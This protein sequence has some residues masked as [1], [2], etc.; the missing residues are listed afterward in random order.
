M[1]Y[2][3]RFF[4]FLLLKCS[5]VLF[6]TIEARAQLP[7]LTDTTQ[8]GE[9]VP[10]WPEDSLGRRNPRGTVEGFIKAVADEDYSR[11]AQYLRYDP[12]LK[13]NQDPEKLARSLQ[14]LLDKNGTIFPY[15]LISEEP[16]GHDDDNMGPNLDRIGVASVNNEQFDLILESTE[17]EDGGPIWLFSSETIERVP[18][19]TEEA[20]IAPLIDRLSP[21]VLN[22]TKWSGVPVAHWL[23]SLL[24]IVGS[25]LLTW[26]AT[27]ILLFLIPKVWVRARTEP[28]A[29]VILAFSLPIRLYVTIWVFTIAARQA[30]IS[31]ILRQRF[32]DLLVIVA[33]IALLLLIWQLLEFSTRYAERLLG[34]RGNQ[35]GV[36][37]VL[38]LR[39]AA[40]VALV[41]LAV[42]LILST[43]GFD[44]TTGLA[45]LGIGGIALALGAQKTVENFVG[46][47]T[48]I[49]DQPVRVG[50][51]CR[52]G[53][54][55][56]TVEQIGMRSTRI[57]TNDRTVVTI[58]NGDFSSQKIENFAHRERFWFHP[59][60]H[61]RLETTPDQIR[62][63]LVEMRKILYGHPKIDPTSARVRLVGISR[64]AMQLEIYSY[65]QTRDYDR[66]LEIQ[67]DIYLR[68]LDVVASSGTRLALPSQTL[69]LG[70]D[71]GLSEEKTLQAEEQVR[72]WRDAGELHVPGFT[73]EAIQNIRN[74]IE[75]PPPGSSVRPPS[76]EDQI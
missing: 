73:E 19:L 32:G 56:G 2:N 34:F 57:R 42:I 71:R 22:D 53:D 50:D 11:A 4:L 49:A 51:Y 9:A 60:F 15:S 20:P 40:K 58:P 27:R 6:L 18:L 64:D 16:A 48:L 39:R 14:Q 62:F 21:D 30:G 47:V 38:F 74:T 46:S 44:V 13:Q 5:F 54:T 3:S 70:R 31:I 33:L 25:Y 23:A 67:E 55:S 12:K 43:L 41:F 17:G 7:G 76:E 75:Y 29:G 28:T 26:L 36:S 61:L 72:S 65:I 68:L 37:A 59:I 24:L 69:Y 1:G 63:L 10:A 52:V 66:Y 45:A 8:K 35:A